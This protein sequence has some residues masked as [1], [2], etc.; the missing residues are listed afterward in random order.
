MHVYILMYF[1]AT[2][3]MANV[4]MAG[5]RKSDI[6]HALCRLRSWWIA[7]GIEYDGY[8]EI[9]AS[10]LSGSLTL[11]RVAMARFA[12]VGHRPGMWAVA[13]RLNVGTVRNVEIELY[14]Q[15]F[16]PLPRDA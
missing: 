11:S 14:P 9:T 5:Y 4:L 8:P 2:E 13:A 6:C 12:T 7:A 1:P 15:M 10:A 3:R 16:S